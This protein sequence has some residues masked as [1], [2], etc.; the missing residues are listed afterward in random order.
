MSAAAPLS[1]VSEGELKRHRRSE[2]QRVWIA[3]HGLVYDVT[4]YLPYHPGGGDL[5]E[6]AA[7]RDGTAGFEDTDH[8]ANSRTQKLIKLVGVL[9]GQEEYVSE[10][11]QRGWK[12]SRGIPFP[13]RLPP[14][15]ACTSEASLQ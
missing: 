3:L 5:I 4:D 12:E 1:V 2:G 11:R 13:E 6:E 8:S 14:L 7:G 15:G 9:S 10:L